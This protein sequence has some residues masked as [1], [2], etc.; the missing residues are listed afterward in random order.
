[1]WWGPAVGEMARSRLGE[2]GTGPGVPQ[3][4]GVAEA[5]GG[6]GGSKVKARILSVGD[7]PGSRMAELSPE[8]RGEQIEEG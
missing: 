8:H 6:V 7:Q 3:A 4:L 2:G 1:M 5:W